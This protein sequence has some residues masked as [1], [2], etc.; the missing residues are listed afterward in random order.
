MPAN[1]VWGQATPPLSNISGLRWQQFTK[2]KWALFPPQPPLC[3]LM[4][5]L[6]SQGINLGYFVCGFRCL[7]HMWLKWVGRAP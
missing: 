5:P 6:P 7:G 2:C 3:P 1:D 4:R